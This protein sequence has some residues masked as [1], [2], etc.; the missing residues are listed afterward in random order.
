MHV[1]QGPKIVKL[2]LGKALVAHIAGIVDQ[3]I[4]R[5][6]GVERGLNDPPP[7]RFAGHRI[8]AGHGLTAGRPDLLNHAIGRSR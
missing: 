2:H 3:H 4:N 6:K 1:D 5:A 7:T 8:V